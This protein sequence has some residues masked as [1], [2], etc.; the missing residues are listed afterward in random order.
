[1][2]N[3]PIKAY[4]FK[5]LGHIQHK[6][7][8]VDDTNCMLVRKRLELEKARAIVI[9]MKMK[10]EGLIKSISRPKSRKYQEEINELRFAKKEVTKNIE[11]IKEMFYK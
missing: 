3:F 11:K 7:V 10:E 6:F 9:L 8:D 1:M 5:S 2:D 4:L